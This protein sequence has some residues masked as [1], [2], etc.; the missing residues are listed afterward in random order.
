MKIL[1]KIK[2]TGVFPKHFALICAVSAGLAVGNAA[3]AVVDIDN[4]T[5]PVTPGD[6]NGPGLNIDSVVGPG[7]TGRL[8]G[9]TQ[10]WWGSG[11]FSVDLDLNGNTL[12]IDSGG[13]NPMN[14]SGAISGDGVVRLQGPA[15]RI[16]GSSGNS[17]TGSTV[18]SRGDVSLEKSSGDA[19]CGSISVTAD[20]LV[21]T[22]NDQIN[23]ASDVTLASSTYLNLDG[24]SDTINELHLV[25]GSAVQTG[26]GGVL[27]VAK[28]FIDDVQ[29]PEVAYIA[30][31]GFVTGSGYIEVGA[32]GPP[33]ITA[34]PAVPTSPVPADAAAT[35]QPAA[36]AKLDWSD[37]ARAATYDVYL[38]RATDPDL[39]PGTDPPTDNVVLSEYPLPADVLSLTTYKWQV[40]A[41][42]IIGDTP[43]PVWTFTTVDRRDISNA[44]TPADPNWPDGGVHIDA[45]VGAGNTGRL[46]GVTQTFWDSGGFAVDLNLN[47]NTLIIDSG[48]GNPMNATGAIFNNGGVI[49]NAGGIGIIQIGGSAGNTYTG[50]TVLNSGPVSLEKSSGDALCG[51]ITVQGTPSGNFPGTGNV[52]WTAADQVSDV[53]DVAVNDSGAFLNLAGFTDTIGGLTLAAGT[54]VETGAGGVLTVSGLTVDGVVKDAGT[55]TAADGFV[56]GSGSV[57]V[58]AAGSPYDTWA[59]AHAGGQAANLDFNHDGVQNGVAY[60]MGVTGLATNPGVVNGKVTWPHLN[61][62]AGF[63]VQVSDDLTAW[64][65]ADPA[66][67]D[68]TTDPTQV[69]YTLPTG[70]AKKFCRLAVTP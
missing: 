8:I 52:V 12:V 62:V 50:T 17:Y 68:A 64:T 60:F 29:Q 39:I 13:G 63:E 23:D 65:A 56:T 48:G 34:P 70:A 24:F 43:G 6:P 21:W 5:D 18:A 47:G 35:V 55:Y 59:A 15:I 46:V 51:T 22:A 11:G 28:L 61:P 37:S 69:V 54:W 14:A 20:G 4:S 57:V 36:L 58:A 10:T 30:G 3:A 1:S 67:V 40:V 49:V 9:Q 45:T 41:K 2:P 19:L 26:A 38:W 42:N 27:K 53:S 66:D 7:N 33:S 25:T 32:S 31:E 44:T 16:Q